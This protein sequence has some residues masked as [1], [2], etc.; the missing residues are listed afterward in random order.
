ML[1]VIYSTLYRNK[2]LSI[3]NPYSVLLP[4]LR[5]GGGWVL[6]NRKFLRI[7]RINNPFAS[8]ASFAREKKKE[9]FS[10]IL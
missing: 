1:C 9:C 10:A 2:I 7:V 6:N 8:L 3:N 4:F 5:E